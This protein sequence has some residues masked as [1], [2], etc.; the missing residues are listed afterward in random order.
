L[1]FSGSAVEVGVDEVLVEVVVARDVDRGPG[2]G[3]ELECA[4]LEH[5]PEHGGQGQFYV[6]VEPC[7]GEQEEVAGD[8]GLPPRIVLLHLDPA[9]SEDISTGRTGLDEHP[10]PITGPVGL[11]LADAVDGPFPV[12]EVDPPREVAER[13]GHQL[14]ELEGSGRPG[15]G[16]CGRT[17]LLIGWTSA[18]ESRDGALT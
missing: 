17:M 7:P 2:D 6:H 11:P 3:L 8:L 13:R 5:P 18:W 9:Q 1:R 15:G 14:L 4:V 16:G 10:D 12:S